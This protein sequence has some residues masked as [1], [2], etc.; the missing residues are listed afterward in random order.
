[1]KLNMKPQD[2]AHMAYDPLETLVFKALDKK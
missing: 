1:M 2:V